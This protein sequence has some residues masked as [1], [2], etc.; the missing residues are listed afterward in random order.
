MDLLLLV[1]ILVLLFGG[2]GSAPFWGYSS[3]WGWGP[4]GFIWVLILLIVLFYFLGPV[5]AHA[6]GISPLA[7]QCAKL[8]NL[9]NDFY[10][11]GGLCFTRG[12]AKKFYPENELTCTIKHGEDFPLTVR[13]KRAIDRIVAEER[14]LGCPRL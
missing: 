10:N 12:A 7:W 11:R 13:Q 6:E 4:S 3:G 14:E 9:R 8:Y 2:I 5:R 1:L